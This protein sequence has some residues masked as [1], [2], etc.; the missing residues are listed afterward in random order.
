MC[1]T[2]KCLSVI[3]LA[4]AAVLAL[5]ACAPPAVPTPTATKA[6]PPAPTAAAKVEAPTATPAAPKPAPTPTPAPATPTPKPVTLKWGNTLTMDAAPVFLGMEK[7][8]F[9]ELGITLEPVLIQ[10]MSGEIP[11]LARGDLNL[12]SGGFGG[13]IPN[14]VLRGIPIQIVA[15]AGSYYSDFKAMAVTVRKD[16]YDAGK[17]RAATD[18]RGKKVGLTSPQVLSRYI[19]PVL[20]EAKLTTKDVELVPLSFPDII[21][22]YANKSIDAAVQLEPLLSQTVAE[23]LAVRFREMADYRPGYQG[24]VFLFSP[25]LREDREL[26]NRWTVAYVRA[27]RAYLDAMATGKGVDEV[28]ASLM[29]YTAVKDK[30]VY[31]RM[32]KEKSMMGF[33]PNGYVN[34]ESLAYDMAF[35]RSEGFMT[36]NVNVDLLVD[37]SFID[38]AVQRLGRR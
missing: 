36:E 14:A 7:G 31:D 12:G 32:L 9:Q 10:S 13:S 18:L 35:Y 2:K 33:N 6:P 34:K 1:T 15:D 25:Q 4:M 23:G 30:A 19:A 20:A 29:K 28:I 5:A 3:A 8:Y 24:G 16:L 37:H 22:A 21:V 11:S 27:I 17:I 38:Y 26:A